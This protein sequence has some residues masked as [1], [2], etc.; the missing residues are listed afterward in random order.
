M[1]F[2]EAFEKLK[3]GYKVKRSIWYDCSCL[4]LERNSPD[5]RPYFIMITTDCEELNI[6]GFDVWPDDID[7]TDWEIY[8]EAHNDQ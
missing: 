2:M 6:E 4:Y 5:R 8:E 7:A 3:E 1:T